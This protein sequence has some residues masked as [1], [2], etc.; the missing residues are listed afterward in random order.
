MSISTRRRFLQAA[1]VGAALPIV[2]APTLEAG[3]PATADQSL[4]AIVRQRFKFLTEDQLKAVQRGLQSG[5]ASGEILKR[6]R[7]APIDEPA[8]VFVADLAE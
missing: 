7:L 4:L 6:T 1:A 2:T 8:M 5:L 3:E